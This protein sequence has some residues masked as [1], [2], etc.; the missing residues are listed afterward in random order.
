MVS[1]II[2]AAGSGKRM[3][4]QINKVF[5]DLNGYPVLFYSIRA[6]EEHPKIGEIV[7]VLKEEEMDQYRREF[8]GC[9]FAKVRRIVAGGEER[10][11]SVNNGLAALS[12][13]SRIVLIHDGARPFVSED[14]I[15]QAIDGADRFGAASPAVKPKDT[16]KVV[17]KDSFISRELERETLRAVQTPQAFDSKKLKECMR[18]ALA[19]GRRCTD[20]TSVFTQA[21]LPV[22]LFPG[23]Y[24]NFKITTAE[25]LELARILCMG[26]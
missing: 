19:L 7:V 16:L 21:G 8:S 11:D 3:G 17:G 15:S 13:E 14:Q 5:L 4:K 10:M 25:D 9:G 24:D 18:A 22:Y 20:D 2:V 26:N 23:S 1:S 6:F 12:P